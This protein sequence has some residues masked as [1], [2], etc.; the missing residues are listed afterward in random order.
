M[1]VD[2]IPHLFCC[3]GTAR[4][5]TK[6]EYDL[7]AISWKGCRVLPVTSMIREIAPVTGNVARSHSLILVEEHVTSPLSQ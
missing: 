7:L 6:G 3:L 1:R 4:C 5:G 2:R